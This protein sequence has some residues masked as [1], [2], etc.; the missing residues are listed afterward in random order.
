LAHGQ[1]TEVAK[2]ILG[3]VGTTVDDQARTFG[4]SWGQCVRVPIPFDNSNPWGQH[5]VMSELLPPAVCG[6]GA[7]VAEKVLSVFALHA[8]WPR[9]RDIV[10]LTGV[11]GVGKTKAAFDLG[12]DSAF[13]L[14]VRIRE[15]GVL[16]AP[17]ES[18]VSFASARKC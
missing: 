7:S 12:R 9:A 15:A 10:M 5:V 4:P 11:S 6:G 1:R 2:R 17:W 14:L 18:Y 8:A 13:M 16:C 3:D